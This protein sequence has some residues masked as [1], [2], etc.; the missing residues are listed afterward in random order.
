MGEFAALGRRDAGDHARELQGRDEGPRLAIGDDS[1]GDPPRRPF[2]AE[3]KENV[4]DR[5]FVFLAEDVGGAAS[6]ALHAHIERRVE[7]QREA[8]RGLVELHRRKTPT[9]RT[10][11]RPPDAQLARDAREIAEPRANQRKAALRRFGER[12]AGGD[13]PRVAVEPDRGRRDR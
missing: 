12:R 8:A 13:R 3:R 9:S 7:A 11:R 5:R 2:L 1:A 10:I 4:G 6:F